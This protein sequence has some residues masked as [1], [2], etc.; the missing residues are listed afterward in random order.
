[1]LH[2]FVFVFIFIFGV[3]VGSLHFD[4]N[5]DLVNVVVVGVVGFSK[6]IYI[7]QNDMRN[8]RKKTETLKHWDR[9]S[10]RKKNNVW[11]IEKYR[12]RKKNHA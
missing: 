1:M 5:I 9:K 8:E 12:I 7:L 3:G 2:I 10:E 11:R 4:E 6:N